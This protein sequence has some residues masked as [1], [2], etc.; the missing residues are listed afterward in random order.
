MKFLQKAK[1][2]L[3]IQ[4]T[5]SLENPK[6]KRGRNFSMEIQQEEE[7]VNLQIRNESSAVKLYITMSLINP[8]FHQY[9]L[10]NPS[11]RNPTF[12]NTLCDA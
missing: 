5:R 9:L 8:L 10:S 2:S 4:F 12:S 7:E 11:L 1:K 6:Q 3:R